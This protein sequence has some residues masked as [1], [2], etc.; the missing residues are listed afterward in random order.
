MAAIRELPHIVV[1]DND[2]FETPFRHVATFEDG[3]AVEAHK[4]IP[5][6]PCPALAQ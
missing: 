1:F 4:P 2:D 6:W 5:R 3:K